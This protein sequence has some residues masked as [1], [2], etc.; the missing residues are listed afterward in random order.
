LNTRRI[1]G[2]VLALVVLAVTGCGGT[3]VVRPAGD[4]I[5]DFRQDTFGYVNELEWEYQVDPATHETRVKLNDPRPAFTHRCFAVSRMARQFFQYA[6]FDP[7]RAK[8]DHESYRKIIRDVVSRR[9]GDS[10]SD[11]KIVVPGYANLR[12]FSHA[13]ETQLKD[14]SGGAWRS[15]WQFSNWRMIFPFS[16]A[17]QVAT[18]RRLVEEVE[19]HRLPL[20]HL[21][22]FAPF[23]ITDIDH[24]VVIVTAVQSGKEIRFGVYDPN[25]DAKP[26]ELTFD[27][28]A[29]TFVF[30]ATNYFADGPIDVYEIERAGLN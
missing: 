6:R 16:R 25:N 17:H 10:R 23:P 13:E 15:Y 4:R 19:V 20:V 24:A 29:R 22:R 28:V 2:Y 7:A 30:P 26:A 18:A 8:V 14:A 12:S 3:A 5:F 1:R 27:R 9:P 11:G 21:I